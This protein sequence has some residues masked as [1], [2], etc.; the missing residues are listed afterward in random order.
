MGKGPVQRNMKSIPKAAVMRHDSAGSHPEVKMMA[1]QRFRSHFVNLT[2]PSGVISTAQITN[3][4][5]RARQA[6][7][8]RPLSL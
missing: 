4:Q 5:L 2:K 7:D 1:N 8:Q 3:Q 6:R